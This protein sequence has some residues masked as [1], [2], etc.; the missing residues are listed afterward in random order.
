LNVEWHA[1]DAHPWDCDLPIEQR[2]ELFTAGLIADTV[3]AI[4]QLFEDLAEVDVIQ[5]CVL[6]PNDPDMTILAGTVCRD[7]LN[8]AVGCPS[9]AMSLRLLGLQHRLVDGPF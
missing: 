7:D 2:A 4:R 5:I 1:R 6:A 8:A 3:V 9:P